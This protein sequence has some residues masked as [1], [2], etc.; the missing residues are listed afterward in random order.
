MRVSLAQRVES[1][2]EGLHRLAPIYG[3][4]TEGFDTPNLEEAQALLDE[5][6]T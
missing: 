5:L 3:R 4:L 6:C 1:A 2:R